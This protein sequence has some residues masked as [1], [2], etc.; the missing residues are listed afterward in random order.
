MLKKYFKNY[1]IIWVLFVAIYLAACFLTPNT[2]EG[3]YKFGGAFWGPFV[4]IMI[5]LIGQLIIAKKV[6]DSETKEKLFMNLPLYRLSYL[7]TVLTFIVGTVCMVMPDLP[8]WI[9]SI[10][11]GVILVLTYM[12]LTVGQ[13]VSSRIQEKEATLKES[14]GNMR[15]LVSKAKLLA[16][17]APDDRKET[18]YKVYEAL[19]Y[20]DVVTNSASAPLEQEIKSKLN[21]LSSDQWQSAAESLLSMISERNE[22][23]QNNK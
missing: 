6:F 11:C 20:S 12:S 5:A 2:V 22:I 19:K 9:G 18:I 15:N 16:D 8:N 17:N 10:L 13:G 3:Y 21:D 1:L 14:T 7:G 23:V 4:I